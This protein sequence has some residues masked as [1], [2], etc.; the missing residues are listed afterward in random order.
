M[1]DGKY[2]FEASLLKYTKDC[3]VYVMLYDNSD[4]MLAVKRC[5]V[6]ENGNAKIYINKNKGES[7]AKVFAFYGLQPISKSI[8]EDL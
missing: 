3:F 4:K 1:A 5:P 6:D 8:K 7:Y 2:L